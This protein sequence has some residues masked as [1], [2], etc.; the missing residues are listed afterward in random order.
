MSGLA[1]NVGLSLKLRSK[2]LKALATTSLAVSLLLGDGLTMQ[3]Q[4]GASGEVRSISLYHVHT[5]ESLSITY[6]QNGRY[7]PSAMRKIN[8]LLR[9]WRRDQA[10]TID[11]RTLD[12][13]WEMHAD[14]GSRS[15]VHIVSGYRSKRT[16]AFLK[17]IGRNVAKHSQ[18]SEGKAIDFYFPDVPTVKIRDLALYRQVGGVGYY[19]S[20][21]GPTGFLH[22]DTA[23]VRHWGPRI[24]NSQ[25]A[26]IMS[27]GRKVAGRRL[28]RSPSQLAPA[29]EKT[30]GN[31][32]LAFISGKIKGKQAQP[33]SVTPTVAQHTNYAADSDDLSDLV[34]NAAV[35]KAT[36]A[37]SA[38]VAD[39]YT[40]DSNSRD[41][42]PAIK[43]GYP[44]PLPRQKPLAILAMAAANIRITPVSD[45][46][47][48][49]SD[50]ATGLLTKKILEAEQAAPQA[51]LVLNDTLDIDEQSGDTGGK[52]D[53]AGQFESAP[54]SQ[55]P[56]IRMASVSPLTSAELALWNSLVSMNDATLRNSAAEMP[57]AMAGERPQEINRAGKGSLP[58]QT[59]KLID[60]V[61]NEQ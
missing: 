3:A 13:I 18:H 41:K 4:L 28:S 25:M 43:K 19:R 38:Q 7:V 32:L 30:S 44:I 27:A 40:E 16:N 9:D 57:L 15:P 21:G 34:A 12:L 1:S 2:F 56:Q 31:S 54:A 55:A 6:M 37:P 10:V 11:P 46:P 49:Q 23:R 47:T 52:S 24:S 29:E 33:V 8:Y 51:E 53:F 59:Y 58:R 39:L 42:Q 26:S 61:Q 22:V 36:P 5:K 45:E 48:S 50:F 60:L 35:E 20:S 14:L 17:R